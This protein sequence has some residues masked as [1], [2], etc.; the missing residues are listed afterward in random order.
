MQEASLALDPDGAHHRRRLAVF[1]SD[2]AC[3]AFGAPDVARGLIRQ[4]SGQR[5]ARLG[6]QFA[7]VRDRIGEGRKNSEKCPGVVGLRE[8]DWR[9]LEEITLVG[10]VVP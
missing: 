3:D 8:E 10:E 5:L 9:Y 2:L 1:L 4:S 6:D 7:V